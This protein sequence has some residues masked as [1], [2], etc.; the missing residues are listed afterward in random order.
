MKGKKTDPQFV[1]QFI[2]E[3]V[4]QNLLTPDQILACARKEIADIDQKLIDIQKLK[5]RRS[6][7]L[8]VVSALEQPTKK[9]VV[10]DPKTL[11]FL[12][13]QYPN[14][15]RRICQLLRDQNR[16]KPQL[17]DYQFSTHDFNF[18]LKQLLE[19]QI[20][21]KSDNFFAPGPMFEDYWH[22]LSQ[23]GT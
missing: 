18:S 21:S 10:P 6:K 11:S 23:E 20:L 16:S 7:L 5:I 1:S 17:F 13:L 9:Q 3:C 22:Y 2:S 12:G 4:G 19:Y 14:I 8:D 15:C